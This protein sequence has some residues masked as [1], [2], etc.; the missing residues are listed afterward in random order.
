MISWLES[1]KRG[2]RQV[3]YRLRD[4]LFS[5]QRYWGEPFPLAH[6]D[7]GTIVQLPDDQLPVEL[8]AIDA[9][10]PTE[11]GKPPLARADEEWLKVQLPDGQS[12]LERQ[13]L[14]HSGQVH[15]GIISA[16]W[17]HTIPM[18]LLILRLND[19]GCQ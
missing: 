12:P 14:C 17:T 7:D 8:P 13:T 3:Q 10:K 6:L 4:W 11:D 16:F 9:Y 15:V 18:H 2:T 1:E 19:T 5:R